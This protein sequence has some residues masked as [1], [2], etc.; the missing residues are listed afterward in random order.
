MKKFI[1]NRVV[2]F[3]AAT[4]AAAFILVGCEVVSNPDDAGRSASGF[5]AN[6]Y[7]ISNERDLQS[8]ANRIINGEPDA[9]GI[10]QNNITLSQPWTPIG[11]TSGPLPVSYL[12]TFDGQGYTIYKLDVTSSSNFTALFAIN[13]GTIQ[14]LTVSGT[15]SATPSAGS[16]IDYVAGIAAY[17]DV[18]GTI[19]RVIS[20]V[21]ITTT[22]PDTVYN[23]GGITGFNGWDS[24]TPA[25]PH[26]NYDWVQGGTVLQCR[27]EGNITGGNNKIGGIAGENAWQITECSNKGTITCAKTV[28]G[29][30]GVGG[31]AG[32]NGN[33]N[34]PTEFGHILNCYNWGTVVDNT[35]SSSSQNGYGGITGWCNDNSDINNCYTVGQFQQTGGNV[36]GTKNPIIGEADTPTSARGANNQSLDTIYAASPTNIALAGNRDSQALMMSQAFVAL[37]NNG[38]TGPYVYDSGLYPKLSWE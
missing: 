9:N 16:T 6:T 7:P 10:L 18:N 2:R 28:Y 31:I 14:N 3:I 25:S 32:R 5:G 22:D 11:T 29:W 15:V 36:T 17:N 23:I 37:L 4:F 21:N 38:G 30:P 35:G 19:T 34:K 33:N 1:N 24:N 27:N 8:F 13:N 20:Q 12:G 26:Y